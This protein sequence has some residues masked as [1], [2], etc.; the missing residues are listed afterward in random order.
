MAGRVD[1]IPGIEQKRPRNVGQY[2]T[3]RCKKI[4]YRDGPEITI[5]CDKE[6]KIM[7]FRDSGYQLQRGYVQCHGWLDEHIIPTKEM[8][9][10]VCPNKTKHVDG[11]VNVV[12]RVCIE[13]HPVYCDWRPPR[14]DIE[15]DVYCYKPKSKK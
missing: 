9:V 10:A 12:C 6:M 13:N 2:D 3:V 15:K 4:I 1:Y 8:Y 5:Y 14:F 7:K 11:Q